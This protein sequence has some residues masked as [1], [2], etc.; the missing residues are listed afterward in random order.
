MTIDGHVGAGDPSTLRA[1]LPV[2]E[3]LDLPAGMVAP[4]SLRVVA[5]L[6]DHA[7]LAGVTYLAF[8]VQPVDPP[9]YV[10]FGVPTGVPS[11]GVWTQSGWV[12]ATVVAIALMQAYLGSTPGKLFVG[13][14]VVREANGRP[15]G[16][17]RTVGRL[18][19]HLLDAIFLIGYLRPLWNRRRQ[20]FADS[21]A[22]TVVLV[23]RRPLLFRAGGEPTV[24]PPWEAP[25]A[26]R[27][28]RAGT[29]LAG[30]A[31]LIGVGLGLGSTATSGVGTRTESCSTA[32]PLV[33]DGSF[34]LVD[35]SVLVD[36]GTMTE[37]RL[38]VERQR[39][40][41]TPG[42]TVRWGW[43]GTVPPDPVRLRVSFARA[44]GSG[45]RTVDHQV[46]DGAVVAGVGEPVENGEWAVRLPL[47]VV[48]GL[49]ESWTWS[50]TTTVAGQTSPECA[51]PAR[52]TVDV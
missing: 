38:G 37:S 33:D 48:D 44:D 39:L 10:P 8:P 23:T 40:T 12:V 50:L 15:A 16:L 20:T 27:W 30:G 11:L 52:S 2:D 9:T 1:A 13:L 49:G 5:A 6:L 42:I 35:G 36:P 41:S 31:C 45:V 29:A 14:A 46:I 22:R 26:A 18:V 21:L 4:W 17:V 47:D 34:A 25:S 43:N 24:P 19:A 32:V 3:H 7:L 28:R 51:P